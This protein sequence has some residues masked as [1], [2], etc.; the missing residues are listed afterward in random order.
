MIGPNQI[1]DLG[2]IKSA[3]P[4][5]A[6]TASS[7]WVALFVGSLL[8]RMIFL[9][10]PGV[11]KSVFGREFLFNAL[12][13]DIAVDSVPDTLGQVEAITLR[14]V[15]AAQSHD[16]PLSLRRWLSQLRHEIYKHPH[17]VDEIVRW[18]RWS[19]ESNPSPI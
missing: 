10:L 11:F 8:G 18:L 19:H 2:K 17:R 15:E 1:P 6:G 4:A 14:P 16:R 12:V 5:A 13:C 9:V 7:I 3:S